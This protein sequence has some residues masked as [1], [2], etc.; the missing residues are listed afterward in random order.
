MR[1]LLDECVP[2][3]LKQHLPNH[4][5]RTVTEMGW[6]GVK[7]GELLRLAEPEFEVFLTVDQNLRYQQ[8]LFQARIAVAI[9]TVRRTR[10]RYI[11]PLLPALEKSLQSIRL[12]ELVLLGS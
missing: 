9:L 3:Q 1:I 4:E 8:N 10:L 2:K 5:V 6:A 11:L 7:N 12:G